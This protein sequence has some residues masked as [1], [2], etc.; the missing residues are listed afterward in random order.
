MFN[1]PYLFEQMIDEKLADLRAEG[2]RSQ[3]LAQAGLQNPKRPHFPDL[4]RF[5]RLILASVTRHS[6]R[7]VEQPIDLQP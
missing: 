2:M 7:R 4:Q 1:N 6:L 3:M 5:F